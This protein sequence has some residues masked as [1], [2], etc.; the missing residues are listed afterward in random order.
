MVWMKKARRSLGGRG[1]IFHPGSLPHHMESG[2]PGACYGPET[3]PGPL[4]GFGWGCLKSLVPSPAIC[5]LTGCGGTVCE[6]LRQVTMERVRG[7]R[8]ATQRSVPSGERG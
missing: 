6:R 2:G 8:N 3:G 1:L 4:S 5:G 7:H